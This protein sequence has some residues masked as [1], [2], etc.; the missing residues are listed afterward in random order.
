QVVAFAENIRRNNLVKTK[1]VD[2]VIVN[3]QK[4]HTTSAFALFYR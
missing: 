3:A 2:I 1:N 4:S